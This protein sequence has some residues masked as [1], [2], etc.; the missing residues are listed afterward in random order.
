MRK[1]QDVQRQFDVKAKK[2]KGRQMWFGFK[3]GKERNSV[4]DSLVSTAVKQRK[5]VKVSL[6]LKGNFK[7]EISSN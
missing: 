5:S 6:K 1:K 2:E 7:E 3:Q 4:K